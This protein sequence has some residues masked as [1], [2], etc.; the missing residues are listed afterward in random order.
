[1]NEENNLGQDPFETYGYKAGQEVLIDAEFLVGVLAF[2]RRVQD[3]Q[4]KVAA[5]LQYP[6][7]V[8]VIKDKKSE[9]VVRVD[10]DW[11]NHSKNSF[12]NTAFTEVGGVPII[13]DLGMYALQIEN[14]ITAKHLDNINNGVALKVEQNGGTV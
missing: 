8:N 11:E 7:T 10:I 6:K 1:M 3:S 5:L 12:A 4:P 14:A 13:T 9:E 2:C